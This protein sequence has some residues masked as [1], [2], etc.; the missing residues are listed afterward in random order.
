[1]KVVTKNEQRKKRAAHW[2]LAELD[3]QRKMG[4]AAVSQEH[5]GG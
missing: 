2:L 3:S 1:M 4:F 5:Y